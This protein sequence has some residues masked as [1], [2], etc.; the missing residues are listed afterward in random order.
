MRIDLMQSSISEIDCRTITILNDLRI[1][2]TAEI[3]TDTTTYE[4]KVKQYEEC[5]KQIQELETI[6][7]QINLNDV[8][9]AKEM[10]D[11]KID[12]NGYKN[13]YSNL[14]SQ[15]EAMKTKFDEQKIYAEELETFIKH[16]KQEIADISSK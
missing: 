1:N 10:N 16:Q 4:D 14:Y 6:K 12:I 9:L 8:Q 2:K 15:H 11:L 7:D 5:G 3:Q 13:S